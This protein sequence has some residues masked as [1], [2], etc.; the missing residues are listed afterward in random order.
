M[1]DFIKDVFDKASELANKAAD[2]AAG[3]ADTASEAA[4][5]VVLKAKAHL[6]MEHQGITCPHCGASFKVEDIKPKV[7]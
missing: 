4:N 6:D 1:S 7:K 3:M 2:A 5:T